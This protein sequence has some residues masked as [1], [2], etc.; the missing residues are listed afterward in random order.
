M[1]ANASVLED[2]GLENRKTAYETMYTLLATCFTKLDLVA[3][4]ERVLAALTDVNEI[5]ILGLMLLLRLAQLS[6]VHVIPRLD[7]VAQS[8]TTIMKDLEVKEDTI[9]QDLE[10]KGECGTE[11]MCFAKLTFLRGDA[12]LHSAHS[13][14]PIPHEHCRASA[15]V[16][17]L[18]V[19]ITENG[20][21]EGVPRLSGVVLD[22][23]ARR[24]SAVM[25]ECVWKESYMHF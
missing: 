19:G 23:A 13:S 21:V 9:K 17:C 3:F 4:T 6:P 1:L 8:L 11:F 5:K 18:C 25:S 24:P 12:A 10:R 15:R 16:P 22:T 20:P 2:E 14:S 7:E